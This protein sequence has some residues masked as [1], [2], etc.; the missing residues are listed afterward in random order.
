MIANPFLPRVSDIFSQG[1][2]GTISTVKQAYSLRKISL[3][4]TC[5][6]VKL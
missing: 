5:A 4:Y 2:G 1:N 3:N 6:Y